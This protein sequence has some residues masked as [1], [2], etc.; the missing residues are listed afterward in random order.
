[1]TIGTIEKRVR[2]ALGAIVVI[3]GSWAVGYNTQPEKPCDAAIASCR[4]RRGRTGRHQAAAG[5]LPRHHQ[6][7]SEELAWVDEQ[8]AKGGVK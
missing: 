5:R 2:I 8:L 7:V 1:M 4:S 6:A 3:G